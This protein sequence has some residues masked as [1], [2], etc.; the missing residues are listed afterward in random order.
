MDDSLPLKLSPHVAPNIL[1]V[2][3]P[4]VEMRGRRQPVGLPLIA[5]GVRE[6]E[7]VAEIDRVPRPRNE[8]IHVPGFLAQRSVAV[9]A[10]PGLKVLKDGAHHR[11]IGAFVAEQ[12][13][14]WLNICIA[15]QYGGRLRLG[16]SIKTHR[17]EIA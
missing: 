8:V 4:S 11:Q 10:Q 1:I 15:S 16:V 9:E 7:I 17:K 14:A 3:H 6:D 12:E 2:L 5:R 13:F